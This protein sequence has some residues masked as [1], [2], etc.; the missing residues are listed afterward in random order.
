[1]NLS[2]KIFHKDLQKKI[3]DILGVF[4]ID[5]DIF[6]FRKDKEHDVALEK[7]FER[8]CAFEPTLNKQKCVFNS[9]NINVFGVKFSANGMSPDTNKVEA[10]Y[11]R[12]NHQKPDRISFLPAPFIQNFTFLTDLFFLI[13]FKALNSV[14]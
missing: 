12:L 9:D 14:S 10:L 1:M 13:S 4:N 5:N 3:S 11:N 8:L 7:I 6:V 2:T